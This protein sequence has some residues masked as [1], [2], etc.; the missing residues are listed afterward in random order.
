MTKADGDDA[1]LLR[2]AVGVFDPSELDGQPEPVRRHLL[3]AIAPGTPVAVSVR[4]EMRGHVKLGRWLPFRAR[5]V[6]DPHRGF[7]WRARVAGVVS[8][9]DR[10]VNG[11]GAMA[12]RLA[13]LVPFLRLSGP[14][15]SRSAAGRAGGEGQ[16]LPT[17]LLPSCGVRWWADGDDRIA[18]RYELDGT[19]I[20]VHHRIG[21][22][23]ALVSSGFARWGDPDRTGTWGWHPWG[24]E[25]TAYRTFAGLRIPS[26]GRVGWYYGTDRWP[27]GEFFRYEVTALAPTGLTPA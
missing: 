7:V 2:P 27:A 21:G 22:D 8:G 16:W 23:G 15:V 25:T 24:G 10:Y 20:E 14:D 1:A 13:G 3:H 12:W 18:S 19:P 4:L 6:L 5:E 9:S 17:A 26:A 11:A